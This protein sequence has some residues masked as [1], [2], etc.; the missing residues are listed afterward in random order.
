M[1]LSK[2]EEILSG[3]PFDKRNLASKMVYAY[4]DQ[5]ALQQEESYPVT[6]LSDEIVSSDGEINSNRLSDRRRNQH[7]RMNQ[8]NVTFNKPKFHSVASKAVSEEQDFSFRKQAPPPLQMSL[9]PGQE[10][11]ELAVDEQL[12]EYSLKQQ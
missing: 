8:R 12:N 6:A 3:R 9:S 10:V 7:E 1:H 2:S 4:W 5:N 11:T